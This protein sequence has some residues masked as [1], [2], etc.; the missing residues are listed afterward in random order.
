MGADKVFGSGVVDVL[1]VGLP[2]LA[3]LLAFMSYRLVRSGTPSSS[4]KSL[5]KSQHF[6]LFTLVLT[7]LVVINSTIDVYLKNQKAISAYDVGRCRDAVARVETAA[8]IESLGVDPSSTLE[9]LRA[10]VNHQ[11]PN[12]EPLF[13]KEDKQEGGATQ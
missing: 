1:K 9:E 2:G 5:Q 12:C 10:T 6:M 11:L 3:F 13:K 8:R 7:V 4:P